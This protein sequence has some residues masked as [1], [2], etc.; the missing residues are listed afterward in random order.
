MPEEAPV[1]SAFFSFSLSMSS[2]LHYS[3]LNALS[4]GHAPDVVPLNTSTGMH[5][6]AD[7]KRNKEQVEQDLSYS[8]RRYG[9]STKA[10]NSC[11]NRD[12]QKNQCV[13]KHSLH[14]RQNRS[15]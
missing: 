6:Q 3:Y 14:L 13:V 10:E 15:I 12:H 5:Y 4:G 11:H 8:G 2:F 7:H 1:I 9:D